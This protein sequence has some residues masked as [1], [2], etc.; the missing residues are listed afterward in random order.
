MHRAFRYGHCRRPEPV[1][2]K[3]AMNGHT[4]HSALHSALLAMVLAASAVVAFTHLRCQVAG[5]AQVLVY[6]GILVR[7]GYVSENLAAWRQGDAAAQLGR[8]RQ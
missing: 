8:P 3:T 7:T 1:I 4:L 6:R 5:D 2:Q